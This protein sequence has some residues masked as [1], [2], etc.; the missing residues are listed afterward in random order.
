MVT[1]PSAPIPSP[2]VARWLKN[3]EALLRS[4]MDVTA[5]KAKCV[6]VNNSRST[7]LI[8]HEV[9]DIA[10][11]PEEKKVPVLSGEPEGKPTVLETNVLRQRPSPLLPSQSRQRYLFTDHGS[12]FLTLADPRVDLIFDEFLIILDDGRLFLLGNGFRGN[13]ITSLRREDACVE[14]GRDFL[15]EGGRGARALCC[16][17]LAKV[18][19]VGDGEILE[20]RCRGFQPGRGPSANTRTKAARWTEAENE[21]RGVLPFDES[22]EVDALCRKHGR[23]LVVVVV[24]CLCTVTCPTKTMSLVSCEYKGRN[25]S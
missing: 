13:G 11:V 16:L 9:Q 10:R 12:N 6:G 17:C 2:T 3:L 1:Q 14:L 21:R 19:C 5:S 25:S 24:H 18:V 15:G 4:R 7:C 8:N 22:C 23:L 20:T